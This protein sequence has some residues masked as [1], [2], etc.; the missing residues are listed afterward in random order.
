MKH[1]TKSEQEMAITPESWAGQVHRLPLLDTDSMDE[2]QRELRDR[3]AGGPRAQERG[4]VPLTDDEGRLLGPFGIMLLAPR[5]GDA[6]QSLGAALRFGI[7]LSERCRELGILTVASELRS[8]FEWIAHSGAAQSHGVTDAQLAELLEGGIPQGLGPTESL[9]VDICRTLLSTGNLSDEQYDQAIERL[10]SDGLAELVWLVGYYNALALALR[11]F[12]PP[13][14][15][16]P[17]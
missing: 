8:T 4:T 11:V 9:I 10:G 1:S 13:L 7:D 17:G 5:V 6:V 2:R 16:P 3:I 14:Q 12:N 15:G